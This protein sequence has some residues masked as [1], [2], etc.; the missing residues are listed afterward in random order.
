MDVAKV[1]NTVD[2]P[3]ANRLKKFRPP[4]KRIVRRQ[5][6]KVL[7]LSSLTLA[8]G[9]FFEGSRAIRMLWVTK[10]L[11]FSRNPDWKN[12][13]RIPLIL[14]IIATMAQSAA[15]QY[16]NPKVMK[17]SLTGRRLLSK[18]MS[19]NIGIRKMDHRRTDLRSS[20]AIK[21]GIS[22][23]NSGRFFG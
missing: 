3:Q 16:Q 14:M 1:R 17:S 13:F 12:R 9:W 23:V 11:S 20:D 5:L 21:K 18:R 2:G 22:D 19:Q 10:C 15:R 6:L 7:W 8:K 4:Y